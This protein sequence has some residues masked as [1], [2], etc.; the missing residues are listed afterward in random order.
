MKTLILIAYRNVRLHWRHSFAA[1][2]SVVASF[3]ALVIFQGYIEDIKEIYFDGYRH[4]AML[5][6]VLIENIDLKTQKA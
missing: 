6:D 3:Y 4:R 5:G 1:I 2:L